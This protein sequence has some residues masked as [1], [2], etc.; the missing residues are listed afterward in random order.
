MTAPSCVPLWG[1]PAER[2]SSQ[3]FWNCSILS[4]KSSWRR[5]RRVACLVCGNR[6]GS[7][8]RRLLAYDTT[9]F[10]TYVAGANDRTQLAHEQGRA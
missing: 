4:P 7:V 3:E 9:N 1:F 10:H 8:G 5:R 6:S 2:F